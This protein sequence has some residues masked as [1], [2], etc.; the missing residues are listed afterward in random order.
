MPVPPHLQ[1]FWNE[2]LLVTGTTDADRYYD[3]CVFGDNKQLADDL[4]NLVLRGIKRATAGSL[5]SYEDQGIHVPRAGDLSIVTD[6]SGKPLCIIE[7]QVVEVVPYN[8]VTA[9]FAA[10]EGEGD[11]SLAF[12][13]EAHKQYFERECVQAGR[14][15]GED[16]LLACEQ[17]KVVYQPRLNA[18]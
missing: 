14:I 4:G 15:F 5:A 3:V 10:V 7:T 18:A 8:E 16:M 6:W 12:W 2:F 1:T 11:G 13:R 17:F 9:E